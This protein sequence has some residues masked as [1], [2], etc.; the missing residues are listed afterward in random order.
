MTGI[1]IKTV[2]KSYK[3]REALDKVSLTIEKG[4][5]YG[6]LGRNGS[7]KTTL[8]NIVSGRLFAD[9]GEVLLDGERVTENDEAMRRIYFMGAED[10]LPNYM[11]VGDAI[12]AQRYFYKGTDEELALRLCRAFGIGPRARLSQLST[13]Q[14][15]L[16]KTVLA[17]SSGAE[18]IFLDEPTLGVDANF[19]EELYRQIAE[20][21]EETGAAF[22]ISSHLAD[23]C[24]GLF[25]HCFVLE[26]GRLIADE[27]CEELRANAYLIEGRAKDVNEYIKGRECLSRT[28]M[29]PLVCACVK[30]EAG[31]VPEG[32]ELSRPSLQQLLIAMTGGEQDG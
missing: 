1:E 6:L 24:A 21:F 9:S 13:G 11:R 25:E 31:T 14:R 5:I 7:G 17:L 30:G 3:K 32:L 19:R 20:R 12:R 16:A 8:V 26:D 27:E 29:G 4:R 10:L 15:T 23:E 2:T 18:F 28:V 22:V